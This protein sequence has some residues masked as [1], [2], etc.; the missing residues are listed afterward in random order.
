LERSI[1]KKA[2]VYQIIHE[3][4]EQI[5][6][7]KDKKKKIYRKIPFASLPEDEKFTNAIN[8]RKQFIDNIKMIAHR[9]EI[10]MYNIKKISLAI[11]MKAGNYYRK[12]ILP[13]LT[14]YQIIQ[15]NP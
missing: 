9:A 12:F 14:L 15:V 5:I 7:I 11:Q 8:V 3:L 13:M 2:E 10:A 4:E 6:A 1:A